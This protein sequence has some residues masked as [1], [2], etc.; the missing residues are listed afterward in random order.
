MS[1]SYF[2]DT[3]EQLKLYDKFKQQEQCEKCKYIEFKGSL[4]KYSFK[5][6]A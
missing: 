3:N 4:L 2:K 1:F 5:N 6:S